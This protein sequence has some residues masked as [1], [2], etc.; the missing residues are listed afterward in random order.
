MQ[1]RCRPRARLTGNPAGTGGSPVRSRGRREATHNVPAV[2]GGRGGAGQGPAVPRL[3]GC[4]AGRAGGGGMRSGADAERS[5][6][7]CG[8][9]L[10][11]GTE[12][13]AD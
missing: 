1:E 10:G 5:A 8:A 4:P 7:G 13:S 11:A 2:A 12:R 3:G 6:V 9:L